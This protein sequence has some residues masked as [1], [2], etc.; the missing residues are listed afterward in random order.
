MSGNIMTKVIGVFGLTIGTVFIIIQVMQVSLATHSTHV[1]GQI[2]EH[3]EEQADVIN[4]LVSKLDVQTTQM[5]QLVRQ[6]E[7]M[8]QLLHALQQHVEDLETRV[9]RKNNFR[10]INYVVHRVA[11]TGPSLPSTPVINSGSDSRNFYLKEY[12]I[13]AI[14]MLLAVIL[15]LGALVSLLSKVPTRKDPA[16]EITKTLMTFFIG[17]ATGQAS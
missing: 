10:K 7:E 16:V 15:V 9:P 17:A 13:P 8:A 2:I 12:I 5:E 3:L 11:D 6:Q 4:F 14:Y 1:Q